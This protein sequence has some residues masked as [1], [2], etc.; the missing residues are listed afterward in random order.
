MFSP[1]TSVRGDVWE[2]YLTHRIKNRFV[3][4]LDYIDY[5]FKYSQSGWHMGAPKELGT[6]PPPI[7]GFASPSSA[8][9][10]AL[11]FIARF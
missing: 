8:K 3:I 7:L 6:D 11:S 5:N 10:F 1:K 9:K 4:K 2:V